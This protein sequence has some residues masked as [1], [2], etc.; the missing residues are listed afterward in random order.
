MHIWDGG[1]M[2]VIKDGEDKQTIVPLNCNKFN[3]VDLKKETVVL[4]LF[5]PGGDSHYIPSVLFRDIKVTFEL[6]DGLFCYSVE[7]TDAGL[8]LMLHKPMDHRYRTVALDVWR[9]DYSVTILFNRR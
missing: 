3:E 5:I 8:Y 2:L 7:N 4:G 9:M 6:N 1:L